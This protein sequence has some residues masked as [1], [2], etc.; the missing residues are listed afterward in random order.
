MVSQPSGGGFVPPSDDE[1]A[2]DQ[3]RRPPLRV[4]V[5]QDLPERPAQ[6][7]GVKVISGVL[8]MGFRVPG[9]RELPPRAGSLA[10]SAVPVSLDATI[11]RL[12]LDCTLAGPFFAGPSDP[13]IDASKVSV[14]P[15][16]A[17]TPWQEG[18]TPIFCPSRHS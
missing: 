16:K 11:K 12:C 9:R 5:L 1:V 4:L 17:V 8:P 18:S 3:D 6:P 13:A 10:A 2:E 15:A 7:S 14:P